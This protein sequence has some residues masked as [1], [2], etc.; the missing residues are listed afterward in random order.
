[1]FVSALVNH[2]STIYCNNMYSMILEGLTL[3]GMVSLTRHAR[4]L[5][6]VM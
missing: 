6:L 1:M 2:H 5:R 4:T 3:S